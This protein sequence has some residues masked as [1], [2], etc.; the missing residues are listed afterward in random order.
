VSDLTTQLLV[1]TLNVSLMLS[2]G[3][4]LQPDDVRSAARQW[5]TLL[6]LL[7]VNVVA[8]PAAAVVVVEGAAWA[9]SAL[10]IPVAAGVL[11]AAFA[12]GGGTGTLLTRLAGGSV[13]A[14]VVLLGLLTVGAVGFTP[15]LSSTFIDAS[16]APMPL[17]LGEL[18]QTLVFFQL[19]PL[20]VGVV[21]H[22]ARPTAASALQRWAKPLSNVAFVVL[23][24]GLLVTQGHLLTQVSAPAWIAMSVVLL[25]SMTLPALVPA[26]TTL[27]RAFVMTTSVRNLSLALLLSATFFDDVTTLTLLTYGLLMYLV[28]G[29][30]AALWRRR[31]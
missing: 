10:P 26:S 23:V 25:I 11:L 12:P 2:V 3:L 13:E 9:G 5:K 19:L 15:A 28:A 21:V 30:A 17:S 27:R 7:V 1:Q 8:L 24:V 6:T 14:S 20:V 16:Q 4:E 31:P 29:G 22:A 18:L